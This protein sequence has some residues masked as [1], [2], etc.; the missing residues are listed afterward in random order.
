MFD[1]NNLIKYFLSCTSINTMEILLQS[2]QESIDYLLNLEKQEE[3]LKNT[4]NSDLIKKY[5]IK[6]SYQRA[7]LKWLMNKIEEKDG[8]ICDIMYIT[9]CNL[10]SSTIKESIHYRH[11]LIENDCVSI[12]ESTNIISEGTTGLCSWQ[13]AIELSKWCMKNKNK[14]YGKVVL[15]LGCGVGLT[16]LCIIK[17]CFPKQY[18]FTDCHKIVLKMVSENIKFNLLNNENKIQPELKYD[19][20]LK[21]Q[22][23]YNYTD[24]KVMELKWE[25]I[26]K[27][28]NEQWTVPDII[29]G[30]DILYDAKSFYELILGLKK[31]LSFV[32]DG[33]A[34]IA[35]TIRNE[36]TVSQFLYQLENHN[37]SF[38]EYNVSQ[39][40]VHVQL[41]NLP[42]KILKIFWKR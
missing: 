4:V 34:I 42:I 22:L 5:P 14:F 15:E 20:R 38:E 30:A 29:I 28:V 23:K 17:K 10:I 37:L 25:D 26:N 6:Q 7:F 41:T 35:A 36:N 18:I 19:D 31:L 24:V 21:L 8:E 11:F 12:K 27:Y 32:M 39:Q 33:Y 2:S 9:Y 40:T 3:I 16:G 13:G 1:M